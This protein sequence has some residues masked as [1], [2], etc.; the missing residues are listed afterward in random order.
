MTNGI[1]DHISGRLVTLKERGSLETDYELG[2]WEYDGTG[3]DCESVTPDDYGYLYDRYSCCEYGECAE[4]YVGIHEAVRTVLKGV[5]SSDPSRE[6]VESLI[7]GFDFFD[8]AESDPTLH[9][10]VRSVRQPRGGRAVDEEQFERAGDLWLRY[11]LE[12]GPERQD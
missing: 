12:R 8:P 11:V 10:H 2:T 1:R 3:A 9:E 6:V 5:R 4:E 7:D